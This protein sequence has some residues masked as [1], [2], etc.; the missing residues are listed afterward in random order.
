MQPRDNLTNPIHRLVTGEEILGD[1]RSLGV[2]SGQ[3][4][5]VHASVRSI[6][7]AD[8]D[9]S[10]V[11]SALREAVGPTGNVVVPTGTPENSMTSREHQARIARMTADEISA[12]RQDM[13]GFNKDNTPSTMGALSE[14]L[15]TVVG[16]VRSAHPQISF[17]AIGP[18]AGYLMADHRFDCH[19]GEYSPLAKLYQMGASVLLLGVGYEACTAFHLAEYRYTA[20]P[21]EARYDCAVIKNGRTQW[22]TYRDVV[23]DDRDFGKIGESLEEED[24]RKSPES[25]ASVKKGNVGNAPSRLIPLVQVV[26]HAQDWMKQNRAL[27]P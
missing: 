9:A 12:F 8:G 6:G 15:R 23:L 4:L 19:L 3:T 21:P 13:Q 16:A 24:S 26:D 11:V 22:I 1:L 25:E 17:A 2:T 27:A 14:A 10:A 7:L 18:E 20:S 5:L